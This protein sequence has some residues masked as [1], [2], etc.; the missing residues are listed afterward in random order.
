MPVQ[1]TLAY[2]RRNWQIVVIAV[3]VLA[4]GVTISAQTLAN[5]RSADER[6]AERDRQAAQFCTAIPNAAV[7][8]AQALVNILIGQA[9][10]EGAPRSDIERTTMLGHLFTAEARRLALADL[11]A[12]P[13]II[14]ETP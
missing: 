6:R 7:A 1:T 12:C 11:P 5:A 14:K 13:Q 3:L 10:K 9:I 2:L 8:S 4:A